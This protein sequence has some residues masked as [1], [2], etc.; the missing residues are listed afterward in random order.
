MFLYFFTQQV[1]PTGRQVLAGKFLSR[2]EDNQRDSATFYQGLTKTEPLMTWLSLFLD[3]FIQKSKRI[4]EK[5]ELV[6][7]NKLET[8]ADANQIP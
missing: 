1:L 4:N 5:H 2:F 7:K 8:F 3:D 6:G